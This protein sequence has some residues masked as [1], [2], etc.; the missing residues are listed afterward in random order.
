MATFGAGSDLDAALRPLIVETPHGRVGVMA[1]GQG[2]GVRKNASESRPGIA[3]LT[4]C[5]AAEGA[6]LAREAGARWVVAFVH[7]GVNYADV[8]H[9]Q[10]RQAA[11]L[12]AAGYDLAVGHGPHVAQP[13]EVVGEMPVAYSLGNF[14]FGTPGRFTDRRPGRRADGDDDVR[15]GRHRGA[16]A[17]LHPHQ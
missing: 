9:A 2:G 10:R 5:N 4:R 12:A 17:A 11:L 6:R 16:A 8:V 13:V 14:V 7:W 3:V 1:F 15:R